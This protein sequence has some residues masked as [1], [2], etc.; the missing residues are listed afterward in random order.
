[1]QNVVASV[2]A[3]SYKGDLPMAT[4][5]EWSFLAS[6]D[7]G[8]WFVVPEAKRKEWDAF[9]AIPADDERSWEAPDF[10]TPIDGPHRLVFGAYE[11]SC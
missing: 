1:M 2:A 6:D 3:L 11:I 4:K 7:D 5:S 9:R 10:A 8:H